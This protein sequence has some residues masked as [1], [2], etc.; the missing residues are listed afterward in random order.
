MDIQASIW[1]GLIIPYILQN[2]FLY[3]NRKLWWSVNLPE[4]ER[5]AF[6]LQARSD[7][8][9]VRKNSTWTSN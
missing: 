7:A 5:A 6:T 3:G 4:P 1:L 8:P 9:P 2:E